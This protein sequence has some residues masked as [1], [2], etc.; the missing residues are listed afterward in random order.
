MRTPLL[1]ILS[2]SVLLTACGV[3]KN[4]PVHL[5]KQQFKE[6]MRTRESLQGMLNGR[7]K[8]EP[9]AFLSAAHALADQS[10]K[11]WQWFEPI[12]NA[13]DSKAKGDIWRDA[14]AFKQ[15]QDDLTRSLQQLTAAA[16]AKPTDPTQLKPALGAVEQACTSCHKQFKLE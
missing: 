7:L 16:A 3:D 2:A 9:E 15:A 11:P 4:S 13:E 10:A 12:P 6:M 14:H 8:Y 1:L 5:R